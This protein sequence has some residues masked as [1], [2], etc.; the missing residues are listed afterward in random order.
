MHNDHEAQESIIMDFLTMS[1][2]FKGCV[3]R[4]PPIRVAHGIL[5]GVLAARGH[6][7][8]ANSS[9]DT[10]NLGQQSSLM[11]DWINLYIYICSV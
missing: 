5:Q 9:R 4:Y 6:V 3:T 7:P 8:S 2:P 10:P 1:L 11:C